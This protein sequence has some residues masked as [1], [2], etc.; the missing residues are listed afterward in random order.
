MAAVTDRLAPDALVAAPR[1]RAGRLARVWNASWP[2]V[3]AVVLFVTAWQ[4]L[5]WAHWKRES[6][7]PS[8]FTVFDTVIQ[9][10]SVLRKATVVTLQR[11][12]LGFLIALVIGGVIGMS[13]SRIPV[14]RA[15]VGSMITGLQ[16]MPS[17]AWLP[18][19]VILFK[20][21]DKA[22]FFVVVLGA[23]PSIANGIID[24]VDHVPPILLLAGRVLGAR[25]L[26]A[27]RHIVIPAALPSVVSGLKQGWAFAW[28][29]LLAGELI[30]TIPGRGGLGNYM[31]A[32]K[33]LADYHGVYAAMVVIFVIGVVIDTFVFGTAVRAIRRRY[34]LLDA[35]AS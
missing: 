30:S 1:S 8:P 16:T 25:G 4:G 21:T 27:L 34:G 20:L 12:I 31:N 22:I 13:V 19:A 9:D 17:V 28:R 6:V 15:A 24:G 3:L 11:G 29:S 18:L 7:L 26:T 5:V 14:L 2:K 33:D 35:A 32:S 10:R 23:A